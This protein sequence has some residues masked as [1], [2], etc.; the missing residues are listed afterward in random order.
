VRRRASSTSHRRDEGRAHAQAY[1]SAAR[2]HL[3]AISLALTG[4][5]EETS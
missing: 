5:A 2:Q 4:L 3:C 1:D